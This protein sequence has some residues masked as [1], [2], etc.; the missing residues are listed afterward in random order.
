MYGPCHQ[1]GPNHHRYGGYH[2]WFYYPKTKDFSVYVTHRRPYYLSVS[3][4]QDPGTPRVH[5]R[6]N[7]YPSGRRYNLENKGSYILWHTRVY[8]PSTDIHQKTHIHHL[9]T[10]PGLQHLHI[11]DNLGSDTTWVHEVF[12]EVRVVPKQSIVKTR[13]PQ[14]TITTLLS[15]TQGRDLV[16]L[17]YLKSVQGLR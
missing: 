17:T 12:I 4:S 2:L 6:G 9:T 3:I 11:P 7:Q 10:V 14:P 15:H 16:A 8:D 1:I 5:E 13:V